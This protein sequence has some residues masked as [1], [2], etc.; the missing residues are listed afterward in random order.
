MHH[1][2]AKRSVV[3]GIEKTF[4]EANRCAVSEL[5]RCEHAA[6]LPFMRDVH[7]PARFDRGRTALLKLSHG[8][9]DTL[10][11]GITLGKGTGVTSLWRQVLA[12]SML[13]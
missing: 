2:G 12:S 6:N 3:I 10:R 7:E 8:D 1:G 4:D 11:K 9:L 13:T 5:L